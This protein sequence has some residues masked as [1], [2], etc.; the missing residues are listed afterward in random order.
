MK[1]LL[2]IGLTLVCLQSFGQSSL[3]STTTWTYSLSFGIVEPVSLFVNGDTTINGIKWYMLDG[4][5]S[6]A[7]INPDSLPYIRE[8][9]SRWLVYDV[10]RQSE[11][12]LYD[13]NLVE[14]ES[15]IVNTFGPDFPIDVRIDSVGTRLINGNDYKVQYCSNPIASTEGFFFAFEVIEGIGSTGYLFPQGNICDPHTGPIRCFTNINEFVDFDSERDCDE[16]FVPTNT[17]NLNDQANINVYPNPL[18]LGEEI[19][20]ASTKKISEIEI[21]NQNGILVQRLGNIATE[22]KLNLS[23]PGIY[24]VRIIMENLTVVKKI[25]VANR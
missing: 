5:G 6:C 8:E 2:I 19:I 11:S 13:F 1:Q 24:L 25:V 16:R 3:D 18:N 12:T 15:Y 22:A 17:T 4:D 14:G 7:F 23:E 10:N 21:V 20:V 9:E